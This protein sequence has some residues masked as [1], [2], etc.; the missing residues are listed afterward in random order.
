MLTYD[1]LPARLNLTS[2]FLDANL[3]RGDGDRVALVCGERRYTY[4][5]VSELASRAAGALRQLG[6]RAEERV[7]LIL[8]DGIEFVASWFGALKIGAVVAEAYTF[9]QPKDYAYY[10]DYTRASVAIVDRPVLDRVLVPASESPWL[11]HLLVVGGE[12]GPPPVRAFEPLVE[13]S[14]PEL[15]AAPTSRDDIAIWKFTTG[16]TG[17]PKAAVHCVHDPVISF[18]AYAKGVLGM[19]RDDVVLPVPKLFFGYARDLTALFPFAVGGTGVVFPERSTPERIFDLVERHRP[20]I[21]VQ[22]PTM[23]RAMLESPRAEEAD[24]SSLRFCVSS[25][26]ALPADLHERWRRRFGVELLDEMGS[27]EMYHAYISNV[28]GAVRPGSLGQLVPGYHAEL[29]DASGEPVADGEP[30]ELLIS[31]ESAAIMYWNDHG[32]TKATFAGDTV[33]TGDLLARDADGYYWY[34]G[35][36]DDLLKVGGIWI[37][38][39]EVEQCLLA[40]PSVSANAVVGRDDGGLT[41]LCAYVVAREDVTPSPELASEL[42]NFVKSRLSPHK[43]PREVVFLSELPRT[44]NEKIDRRALRARQKEA[45]CST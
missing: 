21:L 16:T 42:Q 27:S 24:L 37:A 4:S 35:R 34:R 31:G 9:L 19:S 43:Y 13:A 8:G 45:V 30:G 32:R 36:A 29:V 22:V 38:P 7:L 40:H 41:T 3:E 17:K 20:T 1:D 11:R 18:E 25:A 28:P 39:A 6:V 5:N 2:W 10:L 33:R 15:E 12:D 26:E 23:V 14:E 44:A